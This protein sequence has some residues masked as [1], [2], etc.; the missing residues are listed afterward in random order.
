MG[1]CLGLLHTHN[2]SSSGEVATADEFVNQLN[3]PGNCLTAGDCIC[4][5]P[6]D[7][8]L[9]YNESYPNCEWLNPIADAQGNPYMP[10]LSNIMSYT[11]DECYEGFTTEQGKRMRNAIASHPVLAQV[12]DKVVITTNTTWDVNNTPGGVRIISGTLEIEKPDTL[13]IQPGVTVRFGQHSKLIVKPGARLFLRGTLTNN[14]CGNG[15]E[16]A[17]CG[18][19]WGGV[20]VRGDSGASQTSANQ[21]RLTGQAGALIEN[22]EVAVQL[23][24]PDWSMGSGGMI[25]CSQVSFKNNQL[26][27]D[28]FDYQ[29]PIPNQNY[30]ASFYKC[31]FLNDGN[32]P[33][34]GNFIAFAS[35]AK[36]VGPRFSGCSFVNDVSYVPPSKVN[37]IGDYGYGIYADNARFTVGGACNLNPEPLPCPGYTHNEFRRLGYGV[38]VISGIS[39]ASTVAYSV[40]KSNFR[41]CYIGIFNRGVSGG[42]ML[43]NDFFMGKLPNTGLATHQLGINLNGTIATMT[44]QENSFSQVQDADPTVRTYGISSYNIG[45]ANNRIRRNFFSGLHVGNEAGGGC[46][47]TLAGLVYEC[48]FNS[49]V[50]DY[51]F[52]ICGS[53]ASSNQIRKTQIGGNIGSS[54][55]SQAATG[56]RFSNTF[57]LTPPD[58]DFS[59][60]A[61]T[62]QVIYHHI[63]GTQQMPDEFSGIED[64][65]PNAEN[66][67]VVSHCE[68][69]C[70]TPSQLAQI[71]QEY[72]TNKG[73]Y[74][75][76]KSAWQLAVSNGNTTLAAQKLL[77]TT[78]YRQA[79]D[80]RSQMAY[81][82]AVYDTLTYSLDSVRAWL[83]RMDNYGAEML[84]ATDYLG[85]GNTAA[86]YSIL[87]NA[88]TKL[89]LLPEQAADLV[90]VEALFDAIAGLSV[91]ELPL[92]AQIQL[93]AIAA[94]GGEF[95]P[96]L[97]K[98]ILIKN[99]E[100]FPPENCVHTPL[101]REG[102]GKNNGDAIKTKLIAYPNPASTPVV[103]EVSQPI[104][105]GSIIVTDFTGRVV[106]LFT[107]T[108]QTTKLIWTT[109]GLPNG[110]YYY[111]LKDSKTTLQVGKIV[112]QN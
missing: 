49:L 35:L 80:E 37:S 87:N 50:K 46:G 112:V 74:L 58:R 105:D 14:P 12:Q 17:N 40:Q 106:W 9:S 69:P 70:K 25:S 103:F 48:N 15:C 110:I 96:S 28:I 81:I 107:F 33:H 85:S 29:S 97:A 21:G 100:E 34:D 59:N 38:S 32:Y 20:E 92:N 43:F 22:A 109:A 79:M 65:V 6:A 101:L 2:S 93:N 72:Y 55:T 7:P 66:T 102:I 45:T 94:T 61:G 51:D 91:Y 18:K 104:E 30:N 5:T 23:W 19:T 3:N 99:G 64:F 84:L 73:S 95:A 57:P 76:A 36:V 39:L 77:E 78:L 56:N 13:T 86:A 54:G 42:T 88:P 44:L 98:N 82:H 16:F 89:D 1:H 67:C 90:Q 108:Q 52:L 41:D 62:L 11:H 68:P 53:G 26:G 60:G 47:S 71:E 27:I 4:D 8:N 10:S 24:G 75:A 83:A 63:A 111:Q 31:S